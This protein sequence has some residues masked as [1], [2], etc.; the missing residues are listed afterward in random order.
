[1]SSP[2]GLHQAGWHCCEYKVNLYAL[3]GAS[4]I[5]ILWFYLEQILPG[6]LLKSIQW[7]W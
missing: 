7:D 3:P 4:S 6:A 2:H 5:L 1:M